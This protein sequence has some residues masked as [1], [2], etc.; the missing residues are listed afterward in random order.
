MKRSHP[1]AFTLIELMMVVAIL[2]IIGSIAIPKFGNMI[3]KARESS[4]RGSLGA[5]RSALSVYY[6]DKD[7]Y[8]PPSGSLALA[9]T[10]GPVYIKDIPMCRIPAPGDHGETNG[11]TDFAGA[12]T[13]LGD[14]MYLSSSGTVTVNCTHPDSGGKIWS[15]N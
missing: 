2:S 9:L 6:S 3:N 10:A 1:R 14:W 13:D 15:A 12:Y 5:L 8:F 4:V 11:I 7:G